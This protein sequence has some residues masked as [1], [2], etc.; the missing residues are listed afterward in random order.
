MAL[1]GLIDP[2]KT[3]NY[4]VILGDS[5][6]GK[7]PNEIFTG[8]RYN[9]QPA[10]SSPSAPSS[11]RLKP[12]VPGK[13]TSYDL[14]YT[15][16]DSKYAFAGPR[17]TSDNQ[18][19]LYFDPS[20]ESFVLD[21]VDSTFNMNVTRLPDN[22]DSESLRRQYPQI[23]STPRPPPKAS[24]PAAKAANKPANKPA[25]SSAA[26]EKP[27]PKP[28]AKAPVQKKEP[29]R[30]PEKKQPPKSMALSLPVPEPAKPESQSQTKRPPQDEDEEEDDDDDGGLL[31]EYPDEPTAARQTNFSPAFPPVRRF[32]DFMNRR[33]SEGE[34]ADGE[35]DGGFT[36]PS[37]VNN[38]EEEHAAPGP[39]D[40][41]MNEDDGGADLDDLEKDLEDA[42]EEAFIEAS[43]DGEE[44]DI[45]EEE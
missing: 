32:D 43:P 26:A 17:N 40:V 39:M 28:R 18:Y 45:S 33:E 30:K 31:I 36:L 37:P 22:T 11:A 24:K 20:R 23:D 5:L 21:K 25:G 12:S 29:K 8:I 41:D 4:P 44:S 38:N 7:P 42:L 3:G 15:D 1:A 19:V 6:L 10:L 13:T 14:T 27:A 9:H 35:S 34:D 16:D 2:T